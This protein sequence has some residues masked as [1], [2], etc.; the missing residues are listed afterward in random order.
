MNFSSFSTDFWNHSC[1]SEV[2]FGTKSMTIL[3]SHL[4]ASLTSSWKWIKIQTDLNKR[5]SSKNEDFFTFLEVI[6]VSKNRID[7]FVIRYIIAIVHHWRF[8]KGRYPYT[9]DVKSFQ[10]RQFFSYAWNQINSFWPFLNMLQI[11][12]S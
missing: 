5:K 12:I 6:Y 9:L 3:I 11:E 2:W 7:L 10:I 8:E 1:W 4:L